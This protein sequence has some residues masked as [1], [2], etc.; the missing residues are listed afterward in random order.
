MSRDVAGFDRWC[1]DSLWNLFHNLVLPPPMLLPGL[2]LPFLRRLI[3][4]RLEVNRLPTICGDTRNLSQLE[5]LLLDE[6][7]AEMPVARSRRLNL[8][9]S[10][11]T[12]SETFM[13]RRCAQ[14]CR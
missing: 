10:L 8:S 9:R 4:R 11:A 13:S 7:R 5:A 14:A 6:A 2:Y 3:Q 12:D 1:A